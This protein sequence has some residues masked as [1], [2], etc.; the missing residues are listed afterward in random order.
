MKCHRA[1]PLLYH[2][3]SKAIYT[4]PPLF[5]S[6]GADCVERRGPRVNTESLG[7]ASQAS[8]VLVAL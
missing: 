8:T 5:K 4:V 3:Y 1:C 2:L 7:R 6:T